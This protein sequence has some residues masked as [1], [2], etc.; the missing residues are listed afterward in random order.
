MSE[1]ESL[2]TAPEGKRRYI[3]INAIKGI[4]ISASGKCRNRK[5]EGM[6]DTFFLALAKTRLRLIGASQFKT[7]L[8]ASKSD[9]KALLSFVKRVDVLYDDYFRSQ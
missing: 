2:S 7:L 8:E 3:C 4:G 6:T 1:Q 5:E 9:I